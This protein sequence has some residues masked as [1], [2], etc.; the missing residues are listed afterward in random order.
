MSVCE[1]GTRADHSATH[2]RQAGNV[3]RADIPNN[4]ESQAVYAAEQA[5]KIIA[6]QA[7]QHREAFIDEV[8]CSATGEGSFVKGSTRLHKVAYISNVHANIK[9]AIGQACTRD[10]IIHITGSGRVDGEN[11]RGSEVSPC[12]N[13]CLR[14]HPWRGRQACQCP[15][16]KVT[17]FDGVLDQ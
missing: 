15:I 8:S 1:L 16:T 9:G 5:A 11:A 10:S 6:E 12:S 4:T 3:V 14:N 7:G 2:P 17:C 13:L